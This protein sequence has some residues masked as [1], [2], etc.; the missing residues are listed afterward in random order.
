P[1]IIP[2]GGPDPG[3]S[4]S[5]G[6]PE[7]HPI[8]RGNKSENDAAGINPRGGQ[9]PLH[10]ADVLAG[11][12][13]AGA[14]QAPGHMLAGIGL[15]LVGWK[16]TAVGLIQGQVRR[17]QGR[18]VF[19]HHLLLF[20]QT[21]AWDEGNPSSPNLPRGPP[22]RKARPTALTAC[23]AGPRPPSAPPRWA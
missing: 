13:N 15:K 19:V 2:G 16:P 1:G 4:D 9:L 5:V 3:G 18:A 7:E 11:G 12:N 21:R 22:D 8:G 10:L 6:S 17:V 14:V 20:G 23:S